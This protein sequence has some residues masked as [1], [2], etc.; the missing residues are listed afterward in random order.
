MLRFNLRSRLATNALLRLCRR[1][2]TTVSV[3]KARISTSRGNVHSADLRDG[4]AALASLRTPFAMAT[5]TAAAVAATAAAGFDQA[6]LA[7]LPGQF[8]S[9]ILMRSGLCASAEL[10]TD[11]QV[12]DVDTLLPEEDDTPAALSDS[13]KSASKLGGGSTD[14]VETGV[15]AIGKFFRACFLGIRIF[16][17][18]VWM[19]VVFAPLVWTLPIVCMVEITYRL[20]RLI[21]LRGKSSRPWVHLWP[22]WHW[23]LA[24]SLQFAGPLAVKFGQ[25]AST[26]PDVFS[27]SFCDALEVLHN[28]VRSFNLRDSSIRQIQRS[29]YIHCCAQSGEPLDPKGTCDDL[30]LSVDKTPVGAG[31]IAQVHHAVLNTN[32]YCPGC[33]SVSPHLHLRQPA[34]GPVPKRPFEVAIKLRRP[35]VK[36]TC[37]AF[38]RVNHPCRYEHGLTAISVFMFVLKGSRPTLQ[39]FH[40]W[41]A[42]PVGSHR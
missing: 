16:G 12:I 39:L 13:T 36:E 14:V 40:Y 31:C 9:S 25:W 6:L 19:T 15:S 24:W 11:E 38:S 8:S 35:F 3:A 26:R 17:R 21:T 1:P 28:S 27:K 29:A 41:L 5:A 18:V 10:S 7:L 30:F 4:E 20:G 22:M 32:K 37:V 33:G 23:Q 42:S 2:R 34:C